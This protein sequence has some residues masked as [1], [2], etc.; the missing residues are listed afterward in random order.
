MTVSRALRAQTYVAPATRKRIASIARKLGYEPDPKLNEAMSQLRRT[1]TRQQHEVIAFVTAF[2]QRNGWRTSRSIFRIYE[3]ARQHAESLGYRLEE[4]SLTEP[5]M[6]SSRLSGILQARGIRGVLAA[7]GP[8]AEF[9]LGLKWE[10]FAAATVGFSLT[11]PLS[12]ASSHQWQAMRL[13]MSEL[14]KLGYRR[15]GIAIPQSIS[16]RVN[17]LWHGAFLLH[18]QQH[19]LSLPA[20]IEPQWDRSRFLNWLRETRPAAI[21]GT[22]EARRDLTA[23]KIKLPRDLGFAHINLDACENEVRPAGVEHHSESLGAAAVDLIVEQFHSNRRGLPRS[24]KVVT[25]E[26]S[27]QWGRTLCPEALA[28]AVT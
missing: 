4:F 9:R 20:Y 19:N 23:A 28:R 13:A 16:E 12:R 22:I 18:Q 10:L 8:H 26:C 3:G 2:P 15:I 25:I 6:T 7:P 11:D 1:K 24:P 5:L 27:W 14:S 21:V 17:S